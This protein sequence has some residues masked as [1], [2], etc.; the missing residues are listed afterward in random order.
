M[1]PAKPEPRPSLHQAPAVSNK[2]GAIGCNTT[3]DNGP[4]QSAVDPRHRAGHVPLATCDWCRDEGGCFVQ[5]RAASRLPRSGEL[6]AELLTGRTELYEMMKSGDIQ[7]SYVGA[8]RRMDGASKCRLYHKNKNLRASGRGG[9]RERKSPDAGAPA[10]PDNSA[11]LSG[12]PSSDAG[13]PDSV[14]A[15]RDRSPDTE[16]GQSSPPDPAETETEEPAQVAP[17][18]LE[19]KQVVIPDPPRRPDGKIHWA[20]V[21]DELIA[22]LLEDYT[23]TEIANAWNVTRA[24]V[25]QQ[26]AKRRQMGRL[27]GPQPGRGPYQKPPEL[28]LFTWVWT[29]PASQIATKVTCSQATILGWADEY[30]ITKELRPGHTYWQKKDNGI[31]VYVPTHVKWHY[32][33]IRAKA[34]PEETAG[35]IPEIFMLTEAELAGRIQMG[36]F[37]P[38]TETSDAPTA[39][40]V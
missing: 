10:E 40:A 28:K 36:R 6:D 39:C 37:G 5:F 26:I 27:G 34:S 31:A 13:L 22:E 4:E 24:A 35:E 21:S 29:L 16:A 32:L 20:Q 25:N 7:Y 1:N 33:K 9:Y 3:N 17:A 15:Q 30:G 23:P 38:L 18:T 2:S 12:Q 19:P 8:E 11:V 14:V